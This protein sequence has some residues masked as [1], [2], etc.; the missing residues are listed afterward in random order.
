MDEKT[1]HAL[2]EF[3]AMNMVTEIPSAS[4][5]TITSINVEHLLFKIS[6]LR[7][8]DPFKNLEEFNQIA[9]KYER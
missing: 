9:D 4:K 5:R 3:I 8:I 7:D 1:A 2:M 6:E